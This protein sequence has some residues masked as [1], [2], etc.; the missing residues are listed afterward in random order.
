MWK[1]AIVACFEVQNNFL[2]RTEKIDKERQ[3]E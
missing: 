1:K 3:S 2:G